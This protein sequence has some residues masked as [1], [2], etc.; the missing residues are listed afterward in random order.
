MERVKKERNEE[1]KGEEVWRKTG[2]KK[3]KKERR[4]Y[5]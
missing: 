3:E 2:K 1:R 5:R 4:N